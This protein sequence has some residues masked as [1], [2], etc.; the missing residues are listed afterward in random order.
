MESNWAEYFKCGGSKLDSSLKILGT[1][2]SLEV[3]VSKCVKIGQNI[4]GYQKIILLTLLL[5][6][7]KKVYYYDYE[8]LHPVTA[9]SNTNKG[10]E[11]G[12]DDEINFR[13]WMDITNKHFEPVLV[14]CG[15]LDAGASLV[16]SF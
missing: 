13:I 12:G 10:R 11:E 7:E 6:Y 16:L 14:C 5:L 2:S 9:Q 1:S 4:K 3:S 15:F 8:V